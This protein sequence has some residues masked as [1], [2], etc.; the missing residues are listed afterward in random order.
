M[1]YVQALVTKERKHRHEPGRNGKS[2]V[3]EKDVRQ[4]RVSRESASTVARCNPLLTLLYINV[5]LL[6]VFSTVFIASNI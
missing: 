2:A 3:Q 6:K 4:G 1:T 5:L